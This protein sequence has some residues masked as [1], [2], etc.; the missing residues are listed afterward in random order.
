MLKNTI[1]G[2]RLN[3]K[4]KKMCAYASKNGLTAEQFHDQA[5]LYLT[6]PVPLASLFLV[7]FCT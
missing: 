2:K 5:T 3:N 4:Q 7:H 6:D 1:N